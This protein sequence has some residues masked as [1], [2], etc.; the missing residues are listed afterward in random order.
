MK[1]LKVKKHLRL[2]P[3]NSYLQTKNLMP[4]KKVFLVVGLGNPGDTYVKT[5]HNAGFMVLDKLAKSFSITVEK[6][7]SMH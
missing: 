3:K 2:K 1:L 7:S 6:K 5:R 4:Q